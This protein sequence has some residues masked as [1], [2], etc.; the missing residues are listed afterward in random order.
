MGN[1]VENAPPHVERVPPE[2]PIERKGAD[3]PFLEVDQEDPL[4]IRPH[5]RDPYLPVDPAPETTT[6]RGIPP[7]PPAPPA[8]PIDPPGRVNLRAELQRFTD[9]KARI[10][11]TETPKNVEE[12][13]G[14][15]Q[16]GR[17]E[18]GAH[19]SATVD[20][21]IAKERARIEFRG[22]DEEDL[23]RDLGRMDTLAQTIAKHHEFSD[24][25]SAWCRARDAVPPDEAALALAF[26]QA[27]DSLNRLKSNLEGQRFSPDHLD[28]SHSMQAQTIR[29]I[30]EASLQLL[31][32]EAQMIMNGE[33]VPR[34]VPSEA[35]SRLLSMGVGDQ[36]FQ[37]RLAKSQTWAIAGTVLE[38]AIGR[39]TLK[40][41]VTREGHPL[42]VARSQEQLK[43]LDKSLQARLGAADP[44]DPAVQERIYNDYLAVIDA[45][46]RHIQTLRAAAEGGGGRLNWTPEKLREAS[47]L[48]VCM[49]R[50]VKEQLAADPL[51]Q[52]PSFAARTREIVE[53]IDELAGPTSLEVESQTLGSDLR[54]A[55]K[56]AKSRELAKLKKAELDTKKLSAAFDKGLGP[57]L[58]AWAAELKKFPR[59]DRGKTRKLTEQAA[60]ILSS[61]R[62]AVEAVAGARRSSALLRELNMVAIAMTHRLRTYDARGGLF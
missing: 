23:K 53:K 8:A 26:K 21:L 44:T 38:K 29:V 37:V 9:R 7:P 56:K 19:W 2:D 40:R 4:G 36:N 48:V 13:R 10:S 39:N 3:D 45:H 50:N 5:T 32:D 14:T 43:S 31:A 17:N 1:H 28:D 60:T 49:L 16:T 20:V 18:L 58:D 54:E 6:N 55:W 22:G 33:R 51:V 47:D 61:Y 11:K 12:A 59:H 24:A 34:G 30:G 25:L 42:D 62:S 41:D 27:T 57:T 46:T 52:D 15:A 35:M